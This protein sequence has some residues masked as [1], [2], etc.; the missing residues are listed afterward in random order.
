MYPVRT[1]QRA[2]VEWR[3]HH[4]SR[5]LQN[6]STTHSHERTSPPTYTHRPNHPPT[7]R[8]THPRR[9]TAIQQHVKQDMRWYMPSLSV[10]RAG[11]S[12]F[13]TILRHPGERSDPSPGGHLF[14]APARRVGHRRPFFRRGH[15][16]LMY[17]AGMARS[18]CRGGSGGAREPQLF[19]GYVITKILSYIHLD[20][21]TTTN[22]EEYCIIRISKVVRA[23]LPPSTSHFRV[24]HPRDSQGLSHF[25]IYYP[26]HSR[27]LSHLRF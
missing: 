23:R 25:S 7:H 9:A 19:F 16:G 4:G 11:I 10:C 2:G 26:R 5:K 6:T 22:T 15:R 3:K 14:K 8:P 1:T 20:I 18:W 13:L 17:G 27:G 24:R 12:V 21:I